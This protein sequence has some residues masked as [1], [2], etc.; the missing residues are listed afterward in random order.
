MCNKHLPQEGQYT[1]RRNK[2]TGRRNKRTKSSWKYAGSLQVQNLQVFWKWKERLRKYMHFVRSSK[3]ERKRPNMR[4][5]KD[6][7]LVIDLVKSRTT[8]KIFV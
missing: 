5:T 8:W 2:S 4:V 1:G 7:E 6:K 3:A